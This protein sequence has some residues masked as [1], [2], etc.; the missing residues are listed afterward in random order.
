MNSAC[1][2]F[3]TTMGGTYNND[4]GQLFEYKMMKR[5]ISMNLFDEIYTENDLIHQFGFLASSIDFM[6]IR[7]DTIIFV[8][9]KYRLSRRR[10]NHGVD[11]FLKSIDYV[12]RNMDKTKCSFGIWASR[13]QPFE[14]NIIRLKDHNVSTV[15][16]F[17]DMDSLVSKTMVFIMEQLRIFF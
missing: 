13:R 4:I 9:C 5:L 12:T 16:C 11:N 7:Q 15:V 17:D 3:N 14:D 6:L 1:L 10:E 8:Q 2:A